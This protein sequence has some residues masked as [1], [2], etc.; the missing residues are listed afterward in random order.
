MNTSTPLLESSLTNALPILFLRKS[1]I[2]DHE[3]CTKTIHHH[4]S[5][6]QHNYATRLL[7]LLRV[8]SNGNATYASSLLLNVTIRLKSQAHINDA[9][10]IQSIR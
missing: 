3:N 8:I 2:S 1:K 5:T 9:E 4:S 7:S 10:K 6:V